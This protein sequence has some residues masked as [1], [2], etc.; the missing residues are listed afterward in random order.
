[1][2]A[3][4]PSS[5]LIL[6]STTTRIYSSSLNHVHTDIK[7]RYLCTSRP[8]PPSSESLKHT[9]ASNSAKDTLQSSVAGALTNIK[10]YLIHPW[11]KQ[12]ATQCQPSPSNLLLSNIIYPEE[13]LDDIYLVDTVERAHKALNILTNNKNIIWA[14]DTEVMNIDLSKQ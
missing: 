2:P 1:V 5:F 7:Q 6:R 13:L 14:C 8:P 10:S 9:P 3:I 12:Q 4:T 11:N